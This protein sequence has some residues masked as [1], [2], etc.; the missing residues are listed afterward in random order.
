MKRTY[1]NVLTLCAVCALCACGQK[2][3]AAPAPVL[4]EAVTAIKTD[5]AWD[6]NFPAS[7]AG[8]SDVDVRA[9]VGGILKQKFFKEGDIVK[10]GDQMFLIDPE[11]FESALRR[12]KAAFSQ[13]DSDLKRTKRDYD[14]MKTLYKENAV[15][16]KDHDDALSAYEKAK[17]NSDS[18]KA[19]VEDAE[20]QLSYTKVF[21]PASGITR[22]DK[23][24]IGNLISTGGEAGFLVNI[25][26]IDPLEIDFAI[27]GSQWSSLLKSYKAG[28]VNAESLDVEVILADGTLYPETGKMK[29]LDAVEDP[30]TGTISAK[31]DVPNPAQKR[32]MLPGQFVTAVIKGLTYKDAVVIPQSAV[33]SA[34]QGSVVYVVNADGIATLTP[35]KI[36][37]YKNFAIAEGLQ[38]GETVISAGVVKIK[39]GAPVVTE[40]KEFSL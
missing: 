19:V 7:V 10:E 22:N 33:L 17:A 9:Q 36:T 21:A 23:Y 14:R 18:A 2:E 31:A 30:K 1:I 40:M 11:P 13:T 6:V 28:K 3:E 25:V 34:A 4:A 38:G 32:I 12:A 5:V 26:Q 24:S 16:K 8:S 20:R 35:V 29:F 27:T 37:N 39:P 15:S